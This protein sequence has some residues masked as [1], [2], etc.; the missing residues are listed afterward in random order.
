VRITIVA[1]GS[2]GNATL[3]E[4]GGRR[5]LVDAGVGPRTLAQ[6]L[7]QAGDSAGPDA[8][9]V[10]HAHS[11]HVGHC[12]P[13]ARRYGLEVYMSEATARAVS[14]AAS[15]KLTRFSPR[16]PFAIGK[17]NVWPTPLPHDAAQV[18]LVFEAD[19][20]RAGL[21]T[22]LGEVPPA[23]PE[24]FAACDVLLLESNHD[25]PMLR[26]GPYPHYLKQRIASAKGH[27]SN[28]Q[29]AELLG[30]LPPRAHS[31]VLMHLSRTNNTPEHALAA[32]SR[33]L[34]GRRVR[35]SAAPPRG[36]LR[37]DVG[38]PPP[39]EALAPP[40]APPPPATAPARRS[41]PS[42]QLAWPF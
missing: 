28:E 23:L 5:V 19:G 26:E 12:A 21:A 17:L 32:A 34:A 33:A 24:A 16:E 13:L 40:A 20:L 37:V 42:G 22:D 1:S 14:P 9:V 15:I 39:D 7:K 11:D 2:G 36:P 25:L 38:A 3:V 30:A 6:L 8:L 27:L 31:I 41:A 18:G 4:G 35:L 29:A 10:T